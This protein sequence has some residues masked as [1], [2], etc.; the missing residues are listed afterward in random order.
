MKQKSARH[1]SDWAGFAVFTLLWV[2]TLTT[3]PSVGLMTA[4]M[5]LHPLLSSAG[6][7]LR[8][9]LIS[10]APGVLPRLAGYGGSFGLMLF[11]VASR[12]SR[13]AWVAPTADSHVRA[14]GIALWM[15]GAVIDLYAVWFMRYGMSLVPQARTLVTAGP[16]RFVRHPIYAGYIL[17]TAGLWLRFRTAP[18]ALAAGV[19]LVLTWLRVHYEERVLEAAFPEYGAYRRRVG[20]FWPRWPR[21]RVDA[22]PA[23][24]RRAA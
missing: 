19:W 16:Y 10:S 3:S 21:P 17:E 4:P 9:P 5:V 2:F 15:A 22:K 8:R 23:V 20:M 6:F 13:P 1:W 14:A 18:V 11:F 24:A 12:Y 7:L